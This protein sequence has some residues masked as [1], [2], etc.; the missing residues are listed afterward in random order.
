[1]SSPAAG[2]ATRCRKAARSA[3]RRSGLVGFGSIGRTTAALARG[4]GMRVLAF[5]ALL[6]ADDPAY[7][8]AGVEAV[9]LDR[10]VAEADV[11]SLH[12]PL[13][14][15]DARPLRC[16]PHRGDEARARCSSMRRAAASSTRRRSSRR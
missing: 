4:V 11:V 14:G 16:R 1:M 9:G 5:D 6:A 13:L 2:R 10:L 15:F 8:D 12:V 7:R 3:A